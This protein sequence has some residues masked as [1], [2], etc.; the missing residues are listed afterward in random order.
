M[1]SKSYF[2]LKILRFQKLQLHRFYFCLFSRKQRMAQSSPSKKA[3]ALK[4]QFFIL[5][6]IF[7]AEDF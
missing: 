3:F 6:E 4:L 7:Q 1:E 2:S 5:H